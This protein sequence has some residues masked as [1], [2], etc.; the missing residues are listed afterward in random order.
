MVVEPDSATRHFYVLTPGD[1][2]WDLCIVPGLQQMSHATGHPQVYIL[3]A[4]DT[5]Y[6][7]G[8][9]VVDLPDPG[10]ELDLPYLLPTS[11]GWCPADLRVGR[12]F[13]TEI[14]VF[15][16]ADFLADWQIIDAAQVEGAT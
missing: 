12:G 16:S 10:V 2:E 5:R 9:W 11:R 1:P 6:G 13:P 14:A 7:W 4:W 15:Q 8:H 3:T